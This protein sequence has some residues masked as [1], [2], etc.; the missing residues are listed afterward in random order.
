ML[1]DLVD[2]V[3]DMFGGRQ[4]RRSADKHDRQSG[5]QG[6]VDG[7]LEGENSRAERRRDAHDWDDEPDDWD[8]RHGRERRSSFADFD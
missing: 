5:L 8:R 7:L 6:M 3:M 4:N 2:S 1:S